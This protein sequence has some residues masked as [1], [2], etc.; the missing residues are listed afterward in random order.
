MILAAFGRGRCD[1][2][3]P[4]NYQTCCLVTDLRL[5]WPCGYLL[6]IGSFLLLSPQAVAMPVARLPTSCYACCCL[7]V[8]AA[9]RQPW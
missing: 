1:L 9:A 3:G 8:L 7:I 2:S 5:L 6:D 4:L